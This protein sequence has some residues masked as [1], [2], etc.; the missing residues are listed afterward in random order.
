MSSENLSNPDDPAE[1]DRF[2][3]ATEAFLKATAANEQKM[4]DYEAASEAEERVVGES[5]IAAMRRRGVAHFPAEIDNLEN[6]GQPGEYNEEQIST[7]RRGW[8]LAMGITELEQGGALSEV[9]S[10]R[11]LIGET[12][13]YLESPEETEAWLTVLE[14][15]LQPH[16]NLDEIL[17]PDPQATAQQLV[18]E[19]EE[20]RRQQE[21][22]FAAKRKRRELASTVIEKTFEQF[23]EHDD[24]IALKRELVALCTVR[25]DD[26]AYDI[27]ARA[28]MLGVVKGGEKIDP[29]NPDFLSTMQHIVNT[30]RA[31]LFGLPPIET[32]LP[33]D[34]EPHMDDRE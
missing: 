17:G 25:D 12:V 7:I 19:Y 2:L 30:I 3:E 13:A 15:V 24:I 4:F 26:P 1:M 9:R 34:W 27:T 29:T 33:P 22:R 14:D 31:K 5:V 21:I 23:G 16:A 28:S 10:L 20:R 32:Y 18:E 8:A 6:E 11:R